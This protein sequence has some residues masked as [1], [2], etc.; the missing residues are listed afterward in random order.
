LNIEKGVVGIQL[1]AEH[2]AKLEL[3]EI[4]VEPCNIALHHA[5]GF[6][7]VLLRGQIQEFVCLAEAV[8]ELD[9]GVYDALQPGP[10]LT[11][12]LRLFG[13]VPGIWT[14]EL[15][16]DLFEP[17]ALSIEVKDTP[18]GRQRVPAWS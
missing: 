14:L 1:T 7:I 16:L 9:D 17:L 18:S 2:A 6:G 15:A 13:I 4:L 10:L 11:E 3:A 12:S 8:V 5:G